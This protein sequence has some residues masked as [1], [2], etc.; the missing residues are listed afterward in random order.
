MA[1]A[2]LK[3]I[4][5]VTIIVAANLKLYGFWCYLDGSSKKVWNLHVTVTIHDAAFSLSSSEL[6]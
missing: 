3:F 5:L 2:Y 1:F 4:S 6:F